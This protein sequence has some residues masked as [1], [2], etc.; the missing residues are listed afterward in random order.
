MSGARKFLKTAITDQMLPKGG[1]TAGRRL[2]YRSFYLAAAG[3]SQYFL[4]HFPDE[5]YGMM[6]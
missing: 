1:V 3:E 6:E 5:P 4:G 2:V